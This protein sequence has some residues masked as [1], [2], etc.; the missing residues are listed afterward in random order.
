MSTEKV[1]LNDP[2]NDFQRM[3]RYEVW[4]ALEKSEI[5]YPNACSHED[6]VKLLQANQ[7][8][9]RQVMEWDAV[10]VE[11]EHENVKIQHY[12]RRSV[13]T[14]TPEQ[15]EFRDHRMA[16][17]LE[18]AVKKEEG[19]KTEIGEL[20]EQVA[21]LTKAL[22]RLAQSELKAKTEAQNSAVELKKEKETDPLNMKYMAQKKW[23]NERG[24]TIKKG[25]D[26]KAMITE[27]LEKER[28]KE[29]S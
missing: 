27:A 8:N 21:A 9:P 12:P 29:P 7:I 16:Q 25:D 3:S 22:E 4:A 23:L 14:M 28:V 10:E 20:K 11:D 13:S 5:K 24:V 1:T 19:S 6:G 2:R 17:L 26:I 18:E 15:E